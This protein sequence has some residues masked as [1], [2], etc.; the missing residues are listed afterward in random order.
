MELRRMKQRAMLWSSML[1]LTLV[2]SSSIL[3]Q[4]LAACLR[5]IARS[6][7]DTG[8]NCANNELGAAC[9]AS[10]NLESVIE[11]NMDK[12]IFDEPG[13]QISLED[14]ITL[15]P[16]TVELVKEAWGIT[17]LN[18]QA[19]L[20]ANFN[21]DVVVVGLGGAEM[22]SGVERSTRFKALPEPVSVTTTVNSELRAVTLYDPD[23]AD[24]I[25]QV[26]SGTSLPA[27]AVSEDG[28]WVRV[29]FQSV[30]AW[31][32][33]TSVR[34]DTS[35]LPTYGLDHMTQFQSFYLRSGVKAT[36]CAQA[37]SLVLVQG[38]SDIPVDI[39]VNCVPIRIEST[40]V[41][42]TSQPKAPID[43]Q[44]ELITL[45]GMAIINP[46]SASPIYIPPGY[47]LSASFDD[48]KFVSLGIEGDEDEWGCS[49]LSFGK[50]TVL[51]QEQ[52][53]G[54]G[55]INRIPSNLLNY[56]VSLPR[57]VIPSGVGQVLRRIIFSDPQALDAARKLCVDKVL[58]RD[59]CTTL[60]LP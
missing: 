36:P 17:V 19:N 51:T 33:L 40:I 6:L 25:G 60:G 38:P 16:D 28:N 46:D 50:P 57:I 41:L 35:T 29:I 18:M 34:G 10:G 7:A 59:L 15:V 53:N 1:L 52:I 20:P 43:T 58:P 42:R 21:R 44:M 14:V 11:S 48:D 22:E 12:G 49:K 27:D 8:V 13:E 56:I 31:V 9:Y 30:P 37:P 54:L 2:A 23:D 26:S 24:V 5:I 55:I 3:A 4:D 47:S 45:Y 39:I 32:A